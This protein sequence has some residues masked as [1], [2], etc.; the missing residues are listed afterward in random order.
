MDTDSYYS[1]IEVEE[2]LE[3]LTQADIARL[4]QIFAVLGSSNRAGMS[5]HDVLHNAISQVLANERPWPKDVSVISYLTQSGRST[6]SNEEEKRSKLLIA[7]TIDEVVFNEDNKVAHTSAVVRFSN[8]SPQS[9]LE[10]AQSSSIIKEWI[11]KVRQLFGEDKEASCFIEQKIA[12]QKKSKI[13]II[14]EFSDQIYRNVEKRIKDKVRKRF[15]NGLPWGE[16]ES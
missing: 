14:C 12:E 10:S 11:E 1:E 4:V 3:S 15:P 6:I 7:P 2:N 9:G 16:I 13:L 8:P 5:G